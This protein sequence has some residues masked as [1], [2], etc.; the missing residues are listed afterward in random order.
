MEYKLKPIN[1]DADKDGLEFPDIRDRVIEKRG[2]VITFSL[3]Q[4]EANDRD[5]EEKRKE[6]ESM[7]KNREAVIAN[8]EHHHPFVKDLTPE[9]LMT[10][11]MY[12]DAMGNRDIFKK[13][14]DLIDKQL[15]EDKEEIEEILKQIPELAEIK[16]ADIVDEK[17]ILVDSNE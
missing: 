11:W 14:M 7:F 4:V 15:Q 2:H 9:Q 13:N 5:L 8:I 3:N 6:Q 17:V 12:K 10:V 1:I 16:S